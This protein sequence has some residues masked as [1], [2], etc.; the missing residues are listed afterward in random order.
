MAWWPTQGPG[1]LMITI[2]AVFIGGTSIYGGEG[3]IFGTFFGA[4]IV[5]CLAAGITASGVGGFWSEAVVGLVMFAAIL[6]NTLIGKHV[7][8]AG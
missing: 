2:A 1:Y 3:M 4:F 8:K 7:E 5:G 6:T